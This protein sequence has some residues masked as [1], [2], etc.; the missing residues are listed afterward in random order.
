MVTAVPVKDSQMNEL[1]AMARATYFA[2]FAT[3]GYYT[4]TIVEGYLDT[5]FDPQKIAAEMADSDHSFYF[6]TA[7]DQTS[8]REERIGYLKLVRGKALPAKKVLKQPI[9]LERLYLLKSAQGKG[10]G[11]KA[12]ELAEQLSR[13]LAGESIWLTVWEHNTPAI[14]F[15]EKTGF[16]QVG[17]TEFP[18]V[19]QGISYVDTD[20]LYAKS[21]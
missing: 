19:S 7:K 21:L 16:H 10:Y 15:Y 18:F 4:E 6:L 3:M 8:G 20:L 12:L 11:R 13:A 17:T 9:Y 14:G 1:V 5:S 2:T